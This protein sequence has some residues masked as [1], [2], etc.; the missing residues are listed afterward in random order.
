MRAAIKELPKRLKTIKERRQYI[1]WIPAIGSRK[2]RSK[3]YGN[4]EII[5]LL[6]SHNSP[7]PPVLWQCGE[8]TRSWEWGPNPG[9]IDAK[10]RRYFQRVSILRTIANIPFEF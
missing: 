4:R 8:L 9:G 6:K 1:T 3:Q 10:D 2:K 5:D 7:A